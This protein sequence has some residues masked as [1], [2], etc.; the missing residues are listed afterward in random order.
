MSEYQELRQIADATS[1]ALSTGL[2]VL[3]G[4]VA[5]HSPFEMHASMED[6]A[7]VETTIASA[8]NVGGGGI[9]VAIQE[10]T[11]SAVV[12]LVSSSA[13]D[14]AAVTVFGYSDGLSPPV[15]L[16]SESI[17]LTGMTPVAGIKLFSNVTHGVYGVGTN[18]GVVSAGVDNLVNVRWWSMPVGNRFGST[19]IIQVPDGKRLFLS[20]AYFKGALV[21]GTDAARVIMYQNLG[22][23]R[24]VRQTAILSDGE[25]H[26]FT[27]KGHPGFDAG[28]VI[29]F[30][31][32][33]TVG[34]TNLHMHIDAYGVLVD[35]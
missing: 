31:A 15:V 13:G 8:N 17:T 25:P 3:K 33:R 5:G 7:G 26:R 1:R 19:S 35:L 30:T 20:E 11:G 12:W 23:G 27:F 29:S 21:S 6:L 34:A 18:S 9:S 10:S 24:H 32:E 4:D 28:E 16:Q 2:E 22:L 14:T